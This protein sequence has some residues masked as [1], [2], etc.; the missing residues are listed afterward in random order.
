MTARTPVPDA[1]PAASIRDRAP[2]GR[3]VGPAHHRGPS[4]GGRPLTPHRPAR[5]LDPIPAGPGTGRDDDR[6][7]R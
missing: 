4:V 1:A 5:P 7:G 6:G 2:G 3:G